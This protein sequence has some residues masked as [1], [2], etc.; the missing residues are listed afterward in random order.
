MKASV[1]ATQQ[2]LADRGFNPGPID[3][4]WGPKTQ[5]A[6]TAFL[7]SRRP[8]QR[9]KAIDADFPTQDMASLYRHYGDPEDIAHILVPVEFPWKALLYDGP[10]QWPDNAVRV[11]PKLKT[12]LEGVFAELWAKAGEKQE[13]ISAWGMDRFFGC[14]VNRNKRAGSTKSLHAFG[15]ALDFDAN[16]NPFKAGRAFA[17][18]PEQVLDVWENHGWLSGG[19]A[20]GYDYM[21]VQA[22]Q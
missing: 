12:S 19:R 10:K 22:T 11:H 1:A 13:V 18:M 6:Y 15:A 17:H 3:G 2:Y 14:Y 7:T 8:F 4:W 21:H 5:K 16:R 20:W 9:R